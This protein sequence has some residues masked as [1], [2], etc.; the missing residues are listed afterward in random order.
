MHAVHHDGRLEQIA[1]VLREDLADRWSADLVPRPPDPLQSARHGAGGLDLDDEIDRTHVDPELERAGRHQPAEASGLEVVLDLEPPLTAQ[2]PVVRHDERRNGAFG[3]FV[4]GVM[5]LQPQL[6]QA[7]RQ[8]FGHAAGID[9][10]DR[11]LM[12]LDQ[13]QQLRVHGRPDRHPLGRPQ[14]GILTALDDLPQAR[15]V[16]DGDDDLDVEVLAHA[17]IHHRDGA[18]LSRRLEPAEEPGD[19]LQ[20]T[21]RGRQPDPLRRA[22]A[23]RVEP[24]ET[25]REVRT[26]FGGGD[27]MDL[28][29]D[30]GVDRGQGLPGA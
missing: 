5:L 11:G 1:P 7:G 10:D 21:L 2:R 27:S 14:P 30:D 19:L 6:V 22:F 26:P 17:R 23:D 12:R 4:G 24:F 16:V 13:L 15:H 18:W 29:D 25:Q 20:R 8:T 3:G 9:E 28:I